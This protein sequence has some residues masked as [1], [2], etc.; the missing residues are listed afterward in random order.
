M[1]FSFLILAAGGVGL[2]SGVGMF[3]LRPWAR[4]SSLVYAGLLITSSALSCFLVPIIASIGT[5][6]FASLSAGSLARLTIFI[7]I[8][9]GLP[10]A[11]SLLL[12][13]VFYRPAW[14]AAFAAP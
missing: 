4:G 5:Y 3:T 2:I 7:L 1:A 13:V 11:Y 9:V 6:G 12:C 8:Y 14:K 10:V